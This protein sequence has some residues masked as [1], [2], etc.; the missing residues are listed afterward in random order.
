MSDVPIREWLRTLWSAL[1]TA[2]GD[3]AY[4]RYLAHQSHAHAGQQPLS[5]AAFYDEYQRRKWG[6]INRCC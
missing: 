3:D 2:S 6:G 4:E 5:R 1:R